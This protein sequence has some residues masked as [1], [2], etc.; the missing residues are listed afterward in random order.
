MTQNNPCPYAI[1]GN[2]VDLESYRAIDDQAI[3]D[4]QS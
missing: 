2:K 3:I 4:L 1:A